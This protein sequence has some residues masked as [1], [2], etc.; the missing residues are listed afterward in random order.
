MSALADAA[1]VMGLERNSDAVE[2]QCYAPLFVQ[3]EPSGPRQAISRGWQWEYNLVGYDVLGS[4]GSPSYHAAGD[5]RQK[6]RRRR[7][8]TKLDVPPLNVAHGWTAAWT[9]WCSAPITQ[10]SSTPTSRSPARTAQL[11]SPPR[12]RPGWKR[13]EFHQRGSW[14]KFGDKSN[15]A[16]TD[17]DRESWAITGDGGVGETTRSK[18]A[19]E[20]WEGAKGLSCCFTRPTDGNYLKWVN[21]GGWGNTLTRTEAGVEGGGSPY[22][23]EGAKP[24][25]RPAGGTTCGLR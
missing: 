9:D 25:S 23:R 4:Y 8:A 2:M 18:S 12:G 21:I 16:G 19:P 6:P 17:G 14:L 7:P 15:Q 22:G 3:R 24:R 10:T 20:S 5:A 13:V 1:F 11:C